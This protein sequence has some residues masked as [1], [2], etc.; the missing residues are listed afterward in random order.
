ME[1]SV[2]SVP[3]WGSEGLTGQTDVLAAAAVAELTD[4]RAGERSGKLAVRG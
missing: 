1:V 2:T 4:G 3:A